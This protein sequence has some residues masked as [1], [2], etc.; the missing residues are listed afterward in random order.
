MPDLARCYGTPAD[1]PGVLE[2]IRRCLTTAGGDDWPTLAALG[3]GALVV[4][5]ALGSLVLELVRWRAGR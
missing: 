1:L 5:L 4:L 3:V 2:G